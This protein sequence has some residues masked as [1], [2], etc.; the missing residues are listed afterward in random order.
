MD[1]TS[2]I[3][4]NNDGKMNFAQKILACAS[5]HLVTCATGDLDGTGRPML[6]NDCFIPARRST[7]WAGSRFG[8]KAPGHE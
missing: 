6:V 8:D 4:F 2:V 3:A 5:I 7:G 1:A